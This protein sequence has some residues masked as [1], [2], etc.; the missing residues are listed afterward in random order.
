MKAG[1]GST[2]IAMPTMTTL[3]P[4]IKIT[5][6]LAVSQ[7]YWATPLS[8]WGSVAIGEVQNRVARAEMAPSRASIARK[9]SQGMCI[10][11]PVNAPAGGA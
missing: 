4:M 2:I 7:V 3:A 11:T 5:V 10:A 6:R 8:H 9:I 1:P